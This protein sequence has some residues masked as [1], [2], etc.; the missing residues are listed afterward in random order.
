VHVGVDTGLVLAEAAQ[1]ADVILWD[2][3]NNDFPFVRPD[4]HVVLIDA[5]RAGHEIDYYPGQAVLRTAD[6]AIVTKT[7]VASPEL[8]QMAIGS[9]QKLCPGARIFRAASP[10]VLDHPELV[11]GKRVL[12]VEDGPTL[13]H[14]GMSWGAGYIAARAAGAA[15]L[16]D[17]RASATPEIARIFR[18]YPHIGPVLP[19]MG[20]SVAQR[21][22]LKETIERSNADI[23]IAGTPI[24]L[25]V[26]LALDKIVVRARYDYAEVDEPGL[27]GEVDHFVA[28]KLSTA[29]STRRPSA[30]DK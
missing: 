1:S 8:T 10:V 26:V 2:G 11:R 27:K 25:G 12:V 29:T 28:E 22:A 15:D 17:P 30:P 20:Y 21:K 3:G 13:S 14:G 9:A 24:D 4:L 16:V 23:V 6:V 5:L 19:A 18:E 7:D